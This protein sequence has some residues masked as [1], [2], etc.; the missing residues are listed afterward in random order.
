M[1]NDI[2][3]CSCGKSSVRTECTNHIYSK[4][5]LNNCTK[6]ID[7]DE[8]IERYVCNSCK[9]IVDINDYSMMEE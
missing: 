7:E 6:E 9:R 4:V 8:W 1:N 2:T 3:L 5:Y